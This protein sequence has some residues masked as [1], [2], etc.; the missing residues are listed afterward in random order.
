MGEVL[1]LN[2]AMF[3]L[4]YAGLV[5]VAASGAALWRSWVLDRGLAPEP[6][7]GPLDAYEAALLAGG[8]NLA[9]SVAVSA[10]CRL[11]VLGIDDAGRVVRRQPLPE[12]AAPV[13]RAVYGTVPQ[14]ARPE[15]GARGVDLRVLPWQVRGAFAVD[16]LVAGLRARGLL[17]DPV[18][19]R[20]AKAAWVWMLPVLA[21]GLARLVTDA[22]AGRPVWGLLLA[23]AVTVVLGIV[24][25][26]L[27]RRLSPAGRRV[28]QRL[29]QH[30]DHATRLG[31]LRPVGAAGATGTLL[32]EQDEPW[33][34]PSTIPLEAPN[35]T[36][37]SP[38]DDARTRQ[39]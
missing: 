15:G 28:L 13:E 12:H 10:L 8:P 35:P 17:R 31:L 18:R 20:R 14:G 16:Q 32:L 5:A 34:A 3:L 27:P 7:E 11:G 24:L 29:R 33:L 37:G 6:D 2:G 9:V 39:S 25:G 38:G 26:D 30:R 1:G 36:P 21:L 23:L 4:V 22:A 19:M